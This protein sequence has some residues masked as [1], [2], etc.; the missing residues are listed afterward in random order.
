MAVVGLLFLLDLVEHLWLFLLVPT[1]FLLGAIPIA[2]RIA[3]GQFDLFEVLLPYWMMFFLFY[4]VG[5]IFVL[6]VENAAF[7]SGVQHY[8]DLALAYC[9][10]GFACAMIGYSFARR[11]VPVYSVAPGPSPGWFIVFVLFNIGLRRRAGPR[12]PGVLGDAAVS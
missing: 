10:L 9:T 3:R 7:D 4:G 6:T 5:A 1:L 8:L 11:V 12:P 2:L